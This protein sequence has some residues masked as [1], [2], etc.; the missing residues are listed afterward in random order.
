[1]K[2]KV[3]DAIRAILADKRADGEVLPFA[4]SREVALLLHISIPEVERMAKDIDITKGRT[5]EYEYYYE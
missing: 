1:M 3:L 5:E 4:T 2:Q